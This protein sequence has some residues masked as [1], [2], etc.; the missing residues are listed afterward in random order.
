MKVYEFEAA[1]Q[2]LEG[3][4]IVVRA[5]ETEE[6]GDYG[7]KAAANENKNWAWLRD[8]RIGRC[9]GDFKVVAVDGSGARVSGNRRLKNLRDSYAEY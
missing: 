9:I 8:G 2:A 4:L 6:V 5:D 3:I 1:I 7:Y